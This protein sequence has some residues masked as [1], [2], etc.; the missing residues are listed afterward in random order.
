MN[1]VKANIKRKIWWY[2]LAVPLRVRSLWQHYLLS[3]PGS[4]SK[5]VAELPSPLQP[6]FSHHY[7][8]YAYYAG[9]NDFSRS[10]G[11]DTSLSF[12]ERRKQQGNHFN[13]ILIALEALVSYNAY[14]TSHAA[15]VYEHFL[16]ACDFLET[17][18]VENKRALWFPYYFDYPK[19][20]MQA[21][22]ISGLTQALMLSVFLRK[23]EVNKKIL[24]QILNSL[25]VPLEQEG[26]L[27]VH[28]SG[29]P[30]IAEYP[31]PNVPFVF[32]GQLSIVISLLE[33]LSLHPEE[34]LSKKVTQMIEGLFSDYSQYIFGKHIK[35]CLTKPKLAS[36]HYQGLHAFQLTHLYL[37]L[38]N[39]HF[40]MLAEDWTTK[41]SWSDFARF[42]YLSSGSEL[43]H[44]LRS[45][46]QSSDR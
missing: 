29:Y 9:I 18:A 46:L 5:A 21:P 33:Y 30:W 10:M 37:L 16:N 43:L 8:T 25:W 3:T 44:R 23:K 6:R 14:C 4:L 34:K 32:N 42:H 12:P 11:V 40:K 20:G 17:Y 1:R 27:T 31:G 36:I 15:P 28:P 26:P 7:F 2:S 19:Y 45:G 22:W 13:P 38:R 39:E 41:V 35:Y 24:E